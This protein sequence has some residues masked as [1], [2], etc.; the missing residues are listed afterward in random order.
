MVNAAALN[1]D[2]VLD[3]ETLPAKPDRSRLE[4]GSIQNNH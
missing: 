1:P 2:C 4:L 3:L